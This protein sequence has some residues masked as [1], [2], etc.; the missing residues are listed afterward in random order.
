[1]DETTKEN[2]SKIKS[3]QMICE[4]VN[5]VK[6]FL[7]FKVIYN[8]S[9]MTMKDKQDQVGYVKCLTHTYIRGTNFEDAVVILD[10]SQNIKNVN[11]E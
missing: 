11:K 7:L 8:E 5:Q 9:L 4:K 1:M 10:E 2:I 6:D 3:K